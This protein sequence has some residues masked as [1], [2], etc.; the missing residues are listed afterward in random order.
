MDSQFSH[1]FNHPHLT[2]S[3]IMVDQEAQQ[4]N[5]NSKQFKLTNLIQNNNSIQTAPIASDVEDDD[6][7]DDESISIVDDSNKFDQKDQIFDERM[8]F[9]KQ[10][11]HSSSAQ[12]ISARTPKCAR[13]RNHG[14]VSM[15]RV[16]C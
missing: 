3:S 16:S 14:L 5:H 12:S 13:C 1:K 11:Q 7:D 6:G 2:C 15:L 4:I 9:M 8:S 10:N